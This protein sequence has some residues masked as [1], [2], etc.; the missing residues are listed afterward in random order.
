MSMSYLGGNHCLSLSML[1]QFPPMLD[2]CLSK[3]RPYIMKCA[4]SDVTVW[5]KIE[6]YNEDIS[7][8][9]DVNQKWG[10]N[11]V[12]AGRGI[13][14]RGL[15]V[16]GHDDDVCQGIHMHSMYAVGW[17]E[18]TGLEAI[19]VGPTDNSPR[20]GLNLWS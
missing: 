15:T 16:N 11:G 20:N 18:R 10:A 4:S 6:F 13:Q 8:P 19:C 17:C 14:Y 2:T 3:R 9:E 7:V 1:E 12:A 5:N